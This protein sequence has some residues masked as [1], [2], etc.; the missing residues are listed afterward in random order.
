LNQGE[1][2]FVTPENAWFDAQVVLTIWVVLAFVCGLY[3]LGLFR[4]DHDYEEV[5]VGPG[6]MVFG[7]IFLGMALFL[8]PALFGRPPQSV[9]WGRVVMPLLPPDASELEARPAGLAALGGA[10]ARGSDEKATS[11]DPE[12]AQRQEMKFHGVP[13]GLS[14]AAAFERAKAEKRPVLVDFTGQW[15]TNCRLMEQN[16]LPKPEVVKALGEFVTV[17]VFTDAVPI[18]SITFEQR[19]ELAEANALRQSDL[20]GDISIPNYVVI[21]PGGKVIASKAGYNEV[22][23]F[24]AFLRGALAKYKDEGKVAQAGGMP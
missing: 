10:G 19:R 18:N 24:V 21:T 4:T 12:T 6:R 7:S 2:G 16:V 8:T 23:D 13:W 22:P 11:T 3:L 15:C 9:I 5:R 14:Y 1:I 17:E 20:L